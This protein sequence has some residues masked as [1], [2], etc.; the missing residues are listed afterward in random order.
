MFT[1]SR[2]QRFVTIIF[3]L[4]I[5]DFRTFFMQYCSH[6]FL[7]SNS[8][9]MEKTFNTYERR[10]CVRSYQLGSML[11]V[12]RPDI[13]IEQKEL[14]QVASRFDTDGQGK[15]DLETFNKIAVHFL[16]KQARRDSDSFIHKHQVYLPDFADSN[17]TAYLNSLLATLNISYKFTVHF[18]LFLD[19]C[20]GK[21]HCTV[22][23]YTRK[24]YVEP[25]LVI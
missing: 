23:I 18:I 20:V 5:C 25:T 3:I 7:L 13:N 8:L 21:F 1:P 19:F 22:L 24:M 14:D 4:F 15:I 16:C 6:F 12:M 11:K 17:W 10:G 2:V 9:V